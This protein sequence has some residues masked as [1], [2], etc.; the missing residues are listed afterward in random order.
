MQGW[1]NFQSDWQLTSKGAAID[2]RHR[3]LKDAKA[4]ADTLAEAPDK[5]RESSLISPTYGSVDPRSSFPTLAAT[6]PPKRSSRS[7]P[8]S[9]AKS[10]HAPQWDHIYS[11]VD[12]SHKKSAYSTGP[13]P[14]HL[15]HN[16]DAAYYKEKDADLWGGSGNVKGNAMAH[17]QSITLSSTAKGAV[18]TQDLATC[19]VYAEVNRSKKLRRGKES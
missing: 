4:Y 5:K 14:A 18:P 8:S 6:Q 1:Y 3:V 17:P 12:K 2:N 13:P 19:H 7:K 10:P 9:L 15:T 16:T 11:E